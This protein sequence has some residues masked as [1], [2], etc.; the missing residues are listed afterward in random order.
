MK[1]RGI[2][3]AGISFLT[4]LLTILFGPTRVAAAPKVYVTNELSNNVSVIDVATNTVVK[5][6]PVGLQPRPLAVSPNG[7]W[8]Y[9]AN[10]GTNPSTVSVID[11]ASDTVVATITAGTAP[12]RIGF[13]L[14]SSVA[15]AIN[16]GSNNITVIDTATQTVVGPPV[17]TGAAPRG[18]G[19]TPDGKYGVVCNQLSNDVWIFDGTTPSNPIL[20][21]QIPVGISPQG[22]LF[23]PDGAYLYV[24]GSGAD[25]VVIEMATFTVLTRITVGAAGPG[26]FADIRPDGAFLYASRGFTYIQ[27]IDTN[28][29]NPTFNTIV[30]SIQTGASP[31]TGGAFV[32]GGALFLAG[33]QLGQL[34]AIDSDPASATYHTVVGTTSLAGIGDDDRVDITRDARF[35]YFT[36]KASNAVKVIDL[37]LAVFNVV[38]TI[39]V[40]TSP[41]HLATTPF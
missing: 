2:V 39:T 34:L 6:I 25:I 18:C 32:P 30:D 14:D 17:A 5:T 33:N 38:A 10:F 40:G 3:V 11:T 8:V 7:A 27:L 19:G 36:N 24:A 23:T 28:P 37:D 13:S 22:G 41:T 16:E 21:A 35:F 26:L 15:Y 4:V 31:L 1:F 9:V 20:V 12:T 29:A